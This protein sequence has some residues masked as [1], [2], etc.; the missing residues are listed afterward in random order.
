MLTIRPIGRAEK[1][2]VTLGTIKV[3]QEYIVN[4]TMAVLKDGNIRIV[5]SGNS[6]VNFDDD[7]DYVPVPDTY[8]TA[9]P[10]G[11][12]KGIGTPSLE[13]RNL[14]R[15]N[16]DTDRENAVLVWD[17]VYDGGDQFI[18]EEIE[19]APVN[20]ISF[21]PRGTKFVDNGVNSD[22]FPMDISDLAPGTYKAKVTG[23]VSDAGSSF[24][25]TQFTIPMNVQK[26][27]I[28]IR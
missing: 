1:S 5:N 7:K 22:T 11:T 21:S 4:F 15:T 17:V 25:I 23:F 27:E 14:Q 26:P 3:N 12:D 16:P 8:I 24:N 6:R 9:L 20:S 19:V 2:N 18:S 13:I 10:A 28:I